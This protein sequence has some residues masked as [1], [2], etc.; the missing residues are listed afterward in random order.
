MHYS[1]DVV[2]K[3]G[4]GLRLLGRWRVYSSGMV[5][6]NDAILFA[7]LEPLCFDFSLIP[8]RQRGVASGRM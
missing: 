7:G 3:V 5:T 4:A 6:Y 2:A 8:L 1:G